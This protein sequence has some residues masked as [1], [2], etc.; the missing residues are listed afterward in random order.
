MGD[1]Q[2]RHG[3]VPCGYTGENPALGILFRGTGNS[4]VIEIT[5]TGVVQLANGYQS[6]AVNGENIE[7]FVRPELEKRRPVKDHDGKF[8]G[9]VTVRIELLGDME[10]E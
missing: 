5:K 4:R 8:A 3:G 7:D 9:K 1:N 6:F 10:E 2:E